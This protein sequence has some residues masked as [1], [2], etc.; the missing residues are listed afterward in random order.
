[1][2]DLVG[3]TGRPALGHAEGRVDGAASRFDLGQLGSGLDGAR[4][5]PLHVASLASVLTDGRLVEP[6]WIDRVVDAQNRV[7]ALP[8]PALPRRVISPST[9]RNLREL[10][11]ATTKR[12][13]A[14][15]AFRTRRGVPLLGTLE[16]AGKTG[17]LNGSNPNGRYE[18]FFG[19]A[20]ANDPKVGVVV[21]QVHGHLWWARSSELAANILRT[22]FCEGSSCRAGLAA[23][24]TGLPGTT[25]SPVLVTDL[26]ES[27][28]PAPP[29]E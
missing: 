5:T 19:V 9:A 25:G 13:T 11:V 20:P 18:W 6:R 27:S 28:T 21:L 8:D 23:R 15:R 24:F 7:V 12:G 16:V 10:M 26:E 4:V 14:R 3:W 29:R 22:V 17:N 2:L 1:M